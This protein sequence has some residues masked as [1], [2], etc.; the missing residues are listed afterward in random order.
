[1]KRSLLIVILIISSL[2]ST[3]AQYNGPGTGTEDDPYLVMSA[4]QLYSIRNF[5]DNGDVYFSIISDI[6]ISDYGYGAGWEP[7]G[8]QTHPFK[9]KIEGN[10]YKITG[11]KIKKS[12]TNYI[13]LFGC[14]YAAVIKNVTIEGDVF[15]NNYVG[16][17]TGLSLSSNNSIEYENVHFNGNIKGNNYVGGISGFDNP[18]KGYTST[19]PGIEYNKCGFTGTISGYERVG[20][21][22]GQSY[23]KITNCSV[24]ATI[25]A[26]QYVGGICGDM[27]D[28]IE[29]CYVSVKISATSGF[30]GGISGNGTGGDIKKCS[31]N[32]R[33]V[34]LGDK[35]GGIIGYAHCFSGVRHDFYISDTYFVGYL[36]ANDYVGGIVGYNGG[37]V[38]HDTANNRY[39]GYVRVQNNYAK[40]LIK[41][42][43]KVGGILSGYT[44]SNNPLIENN[45]C[46]CT[47]IDSET[48]NVGRIQARQGGA[49]PK[50]CYSIYSTKVNVAGVS[51]TEEDIE[52]KS[53]LH[54]KDIGENNLKTST[55]YQGLSWDF[56]NTWGIIDT[57]CIPYLQTQAAPPVIQSS[58]KC[59]DT[60]ISGNSFNGGTVMVMIGESEYVTST[61]NNKWSITVPNLQSGEKVFVKAKSDNLFPSYSIEKYVLYDGDGTKEAP[62]LVKTYMD[63]K[64]MH[65]DGYYKLENDIDVAISLNDE[66]PMEGW[67]PLGVYADP[68]TNF[69]GDNHMIS[70]LFISRNSDY[71]GLF[72][73]LSNAN[74][75]NLTIV[76]KTEMGV[77]GKDNV[78]ALAGRLNNC[79]IE[80]VS[81]KGSVTGKN[82]VGGVAGQV[83]GGVMNNV[84]VTGASIKGKYNI[85]GLAG[86]SSATVTLCHFD[87]KITDIVEKG[88]DITTNNY[89]GGIAAISKGTI[90]KTMVGGEVTATRENSKSGGLVGENYSLVSDCYSTA[91]VNGNMYAAGIAA[92]NYSIVDKC[93]ASG[94]IVTTDTCT[95]SVACGLV[96]YNEGADAVVTNSAAMNEY[97][98]SSSDVGTVY[99]IVGGIKNGAQIPGRT[100]HTLQNM[101]LSINGIRQSLNDNPFNGYKRDDDT[102]KTQAL[103]VGKE[104]DFTST[105]NILEG[106]SYPYLKQLRID[107]SDS[108]T[109]FPQDDEPS[110]GDDTDISKFSDA[111]Y[112]ESMD[113]KTGEQTIIPIKM[114]NVNPIRGFQFDLYL[115]E[116][117][118]VAKNA[119]GRILAL[120]N[121]ERLPEDDEHTL[122]IVEQS[123]GA[124]RF[125]CGS[126]YDE[127]FIGNDGDIV[128]LTVNVA[129]D[130][131]DGSY[132]L[133]IS[134]ATMTETDISKFSIVD[135]VKSTLNVSSYILGDINNDKDVDVRDY[136]GVANHIMGN[137]PEGFIFKAGDVDESGSIDVRDYTGIANIIMT[138]TV[139]GRVNNISNSAMSK[140]ATPIFVDIAD[141]D[142]YIYVMDVSGNP[143]S[144]LNLSIYMKNVN[145]IRGF[146]FDLYLPEGVTVAKNT[147]GRILS[148][149]NSERLPE[150]DEHTLTIVEQSD[151]AIRFLCSSLYDENFIGND[152]EIVNL[153]V[154]IADNM[155][156]GDYDIVVKNA[157][158]TE[159][160]ISKSYE[161]DDIKSTLTVLDQTGVETVTYTISYALAGGTVA[162]ENPTT[163]TIESDAITLNNPTRDGYTFAGWTGTDLTEAT[164]TVTIAQGSTGN[165]TYTA[166]WTKNE[167]T[168]L[169]D[170]SNQSNGNKNAN[171]ISAASGDN[172]QYEVTLSGRTLF[173]DGSW[174]TLCLP[175]EVDLTATDCPL[176]GATARTV[177]E[178]SISGTTLN[179]TFGDAVNTLEA[180]T[181]YIIKW[182]GDGTSN[183]ENPVFEGVTIEAIK[184]DYDTNKESVTTDERVR[185][186][187]TYKSTAF[188]AENKSILLMGEE[189]TLYYPAEGAGIGSFRAYFK[190]SDEG[191]LLAR[192]LTSFSIDFGEGEEKATGIVEVEANT[193]L[194]TLH[195]SLKD[196]WHTLDGHRLQ[197]KPTQGGIYIKNGKKITVK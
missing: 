134:N 45:V 63:L 47:T 194:S 176:Y 149:L 59:N 165:R 50:K 156:N 184:N 33:I 139:S 103:Y 74:I 113:V 48:E 65:G 26:D 189:N 64:N 124:I 195:S 183:I 127:N 58:L 166:T 92:T 122:T 91:N 56:G 19:G 95:Q 100:N 132:A 157:I 55:F 175:F 73:S 180:G 61:K 123:D 174:N 151:G 16:G 13:G 179:L 109:V 14:T 24:D 99:R 186:I 128:Y 31:V 191:A 106:K 7:I 12:N 182:D 42:H 51:I 18:N 125:L 52:S 53:S 41:G 66:A 153:I 148:T 94:N 97:I 188:D 121:S 5:L 68:I 71:V 46:M 27:R 116:G 187:G 79:I 185:F 93:Y 105:W 158:M 20:G 8:D 143:D 111:V 69:D 130:M 140:V 23:S 98:I 4:D 96:C 29:N 171:I 197:G 10:G 75:K 170:D 177:T 88:D 85:G 32:G 86:F 145:P 89:V 193:S 196:A 34:A 101:V 181:P 49:T 39:W 108:G 36:K 136:T 76:T 90:S 82:T 77:Q 168:L 83:I 21:I 190:I 30:V 164:E 112:I 138:G 163:Y 147:K 118:T 84:I 110:V 15:G 80:N 144:Q 126:L 6:D 159:T 78:G 54:G 150:D 135:Y 102:F 57:E 146:Q 173:K 178:A 44:Y 167:L 38:W 72:A 137:T 162:T 160:D 119:K 172:K 169:D 87:G 11:L 107:Q 117:V 9:G 81:I 70:N 131:E 60:M 1:M 133:I 25:N 43:D 141:V 161:A 3:Y 192:R 67:Q 115:P 129:D 62:Y 120:L 37:D 152:G 40:A 155:A 142:N 154:N 114:K 35:V 104:W 22:V 2:L 28:L 17:I